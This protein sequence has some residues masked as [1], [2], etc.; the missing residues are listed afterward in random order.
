LIISGILFDIG[1]VFQ[2]A[3]RGNLAILYVGRVISGLGVG[4]SSMLTPTFISEMSPK[5]VRGMTTMVFGFSI[6]F[7]IA[8]AYWVDYACESRLTGSSQYVVPIAL[9]LIPGT[10][11]VLG[12]IPLRESPRFL[13]KRGHK[14]EA[15]EALVYV[16]QKDQSM[17]ETNEE[18]A[19]ICDAVD[20]ELSETNGVKFKEV[21]LKGNRE[22]FMLGIGLMIAQ[23][24]SGTLS[25]TY[26]APIFFELVGLS[27]VSTGLFATGVYGIVKTV[28]TVIAILFLIERIGRRWSLIIGAIGMACTLLI[29]GCIYATLPPQ[30]DGVISPASYAMIVMIYIY[31]I[32]YAISWG[33]VPWTYVSEIY[34]TRIR[35]YGVTTASATQWAIN[36]CMSRAIPVAVQNIKWRIF[37]MFAAFNFLNAI[38]TYFFV[39]ETAGL[40]LE[41]MDALFGSP[42]AI[43]VNESHER[44]A[45]IVANA[46]EEDA[47]T[48]TVTHVEEI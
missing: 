15:Y 6:F 36:Y 45:A 20:R 22:R 39:K 37:I 26:Y 27:G 16:R 1:A 25:F 30:T 42:A 40:S 2:T 48:L 12:M 29:C 28:S 44:A 23:Q 38:L 8:I 46:E 11:L 17:E 31:C 41:E 3:A 10:A 9:Q 7:S 19:E 35:E 5:R 32:N 4:S 43:D 34:P 14:H 33:P 13:V 18:F 21:L 24:T 47:K